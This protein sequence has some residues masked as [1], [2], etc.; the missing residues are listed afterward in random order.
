[1]RLSELANL[2]IVDLDNEGERIKV[3]GKGRK[4]RYV[5]YTKEAKRAVWRYMA[6]RDDKLP[7]LWLTEEKTPIKAAGI[8]IALTRLY[9]RAGFKVKDV[10]HIFRRTWAMRKIDEGVPLKY[11]QIIGGWEDITTLDIY[12][13]AADADKALKAMKR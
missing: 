12:V 8:R 2:A 6:Y 5:E 9:A 11:I 3:F 1:M 7:N 13:R 10:A 4:E